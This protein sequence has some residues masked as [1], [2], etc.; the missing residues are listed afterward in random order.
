[1]TSTV[2]SVP[3]LAD[4]LA[5][6]PAPLYA[7]GGPRP[8]PGTLTALFFDAVERHDRPDALLYKVRGVWEPMSHRTILERVRRAALGLARLGIVSG[9]RVGILS[10]N[11]PEWLIADYACLCSG[12]TDVPIYPTLPAEQI[13]YL[14][15]DSGARAVFVSTPEQAR[16]LASVRAEAPGVQWVIGF[17]A[18]KS[19]GCDLTLADLE[20]MGAPDDTPDRATVFKEAALAITPDRLV[21]LIYTSGTTGHPKGVMLTHDNVYSNCVAVRSALSVTSAD[22]ALSFLPLSHIFERTGDYF[23]FSLGVR[24]AYAESID[25]V[26]V[27]MTEVKPSLMMSVP[28]LYEKIYARVLENAVAG[29]GL[30]QRIFFWA[31]AVGE[32]WA[33]ERLAGRTPGGLLAMQYSLAQKLV[34]SKLKER[35]GG[36]LRF[37]VS[38]GAPLSPDIARFFYSAGLTILE[39]YGLTETSPVISCNTEQH[40]RIGTVGRPIAGVE[41]MIAPDGEILSRGPHI[42]QGYY[43]NPAAT[44]ETIDAE[45]WFHTGDI[46]VLEDG[47]LRITDRK[48]DIIVTAGGK[49]IAPQPIE[50]LLKHNKYVS[51]AVMLGDKRKFPIVL[52]VPD[53]D[54][55]EKW[56]ATQGIVWTSRAEL[57]AMPTINA[58]MEKEVF[59]ALEGLAKFERPKKLALLEHDFTIERGELT[60]KLSVKRKV[61]TE[62]YKDRIDALYADAE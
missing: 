40:I 21:T 59:G 17:A 22:T 31:K 49:N 19:D 46:G 51:Q 55:L 23:L 43:N 9:D 47:F 27:N 42:M 14:L 38:G 26:P 52:I 60:P 3:S 18:T 53:W 36:N 37:F 58:K 13:P 61:I 32:R 54:Q 39:G 16:K 15:Q 56:A 12:V 35:T 44:R 34:F 4:T 10:E 33:N 24:I 28:R 30:K 8:A 57:L 1:M 11:R 5:G 7:Q 41:V 6:V 50:G 48:K 20:A 62:R 2:S 45:G 25:T 29:G